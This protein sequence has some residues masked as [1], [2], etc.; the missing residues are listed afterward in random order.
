MNITILNKQDY[1]EF[2]K[3]QGKS[4]INNDT[5][6]NFILASER[7]LDTMALCG[8]R[9]KPS[10]GKL[11]EKRLYTAPNKERIHLFR[12]KTNDNSISEG[13]QEITQNDLDI[14][15][16]VN[17]KYVEEVIKY[18]FE[19]DELNISTPSD[20]LSEILFNDE[21]KTISDL[22]V[23]ELIDN[24]YEVVI[25]TGEIRKRLQNSISSSDIMLS[26]NKLSTMSI[27]G[28]YMV[29]TKN[30]A[31]PVNVTGNLFN[32]SIIKEK[33]NGRIYICF[34]FNTIWGMLYL[35]NIHMGNISW[36]NNDKY[37]RLNIATKNIIN[38]VMS[39]EN[40]RF[41]RKTDDIL[42]IFN[43]KV[44]RNRERAIKRLEIYLNELHDI[45]L[46]E[47]RVDKDTYYIEHRLTPTKISI[48]IEN[49][50][51]YV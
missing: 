10:R 15:R 12:P 6:K 17:T 22:E 25:T 44:S 29:R 47:W 39:F 2:I 46:I 40:K 27:N 16:A 50:K 5:D 23:L 36:I 3:E 11:S 32:Y 51:E 14:L 33:L 42:K 24:K 30:G 49:S 45:G 18:K 41:F 48:D 19:K 38:I 1:I 13:Y 8:I 9:E 37:L 4:S 34:I 26:V 21:L 20:S 31:K 28:N 7:A 43:I 35:N